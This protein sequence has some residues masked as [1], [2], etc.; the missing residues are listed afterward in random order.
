MAKDERRDPITFVARFGCGFV[1][2]VATLFVLLQMSSVSVR[3]F[4]LLALGAGALGGLGAWI[5]GDFFWNI[6]LRRW[7]GP[8]RDDWE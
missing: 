3:D 4:L 5:F 2:G 1:F 6:V 8:G 7:R